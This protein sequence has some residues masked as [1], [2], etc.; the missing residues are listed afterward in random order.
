M[1]R[2]LL[3]RHWIAYQQ[4][5]IDFVYFFFFFDLV[6]SD[7]IRFHCTHS[8]AC[9]LYLSRIWTHSTFNRFSYQ[10][11]TWVENS[12]SYGGSDVAN[13]WV[14]EH[15][16]ERTFLGN[17]CG[18]QSNTMGRMYACI[19]FKIGHDDSNNNTRSSNNIKYVS[20][21]I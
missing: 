16:R 17:V 3:Y 9:S 19:Q 1:L 5:F 2:C 13:E 14:S 4:C 20:I 15:K 21:H 12:W 7:I 6:V 11:Q 8:F 10:L 18:W